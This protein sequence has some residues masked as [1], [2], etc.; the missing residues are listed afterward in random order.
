MTPLRAS[1]PVAAQD[2]DPER[3]TTMS[4]RARTTVTTLAV[5]AAVLGVTT[6]V[7]A[8][9]AGAGAVTPHVFTS[10]RD[11]DSEIYTRAVKGSPMK[12]TNNDAEDYGAVW[13]PDG[14]RLAF[15]S[16]RDGDREVFVMNAD[17]R[18]VRQLTSNTTTEDGA[19]V[20]DQAPA[21]S[22]DGTRIAFASTRDGGEPEIYVMSADGSNQVRLTTT[23]V[24]VSD[25]TPA[26][27]PDGQYIVFGSDR[28]SYEN[29]E[30][31]RMRAD[32]TQVT[33]L[34][35]TEEG[36]DDNAPEYSPDGTRIVFSSTRSGY[37][38]DLFT[39][40][41]DGTDVRRLGGDPNLDDVFP[42]W[43]S[44]G[45]TV[46]FE[47]FAGPEGRPS[48]DIWT[49]DSDGTDRRRLSTSS[50]GESFADPHPQQ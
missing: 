50:R 41:A 18:N 4:R 6:V 38:H 23:E 49:I 29:Y 31:F 2:R 7:G 16:T 11:G 9:P 37:Q 13:S 19:P 39:M 47:T 10:D 44:D 40:N 33:R 8:T 12:L 22:P 28:V 17:G 24:W 27:S 35:T 20:N 30:L 21:W 3:G 14:K 36:V 26:W 34:T 25:H 15:V 48:E 42:H 5:T 46:L 45:T 1:D 32:G 43:T